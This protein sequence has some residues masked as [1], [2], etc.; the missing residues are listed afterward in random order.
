MCAWA[1]ETFPDLSLAPAEPRLGSEGMPNMGLDAAQAGLVQRFH[2]SDAQD[3]IG[4]FIAKF[5]KGAPS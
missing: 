2:P 4:F 3:T 5:T 1:L